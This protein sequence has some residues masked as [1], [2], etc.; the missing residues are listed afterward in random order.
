M[1]VYRLVYS[2]KYWTT[3]PYKSEAN[4]PEEAAASMYQE[5]L[6]SFYNTDDDVAYAILVAE[7]GD[8]VRG[9]RLKLVGVGSKPDGWRVVLRR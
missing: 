9:Y 4:S 3:Q 5:C 7:N 1:E 6:G 8:K 2:G